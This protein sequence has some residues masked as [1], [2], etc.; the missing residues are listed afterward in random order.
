MDGLPRHIPALSHRNA[1]K[2]QNFAGIFQNLAVHA[3]FLHGILC[4]HALHLLLAL[5]VGVEDIT[6][7][8]C[9]R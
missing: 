8:R 3:L 1:R 4:G 9:N 6:G 2:T 7:N 5:E